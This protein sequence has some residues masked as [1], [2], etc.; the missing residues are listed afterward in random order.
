MIM[1]KK[2]FI[3]T[4]LLLLWG[5]MMHAQAVVTVVTTDVCSQP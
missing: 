3:M 1:C 4:M 2:T 5:G